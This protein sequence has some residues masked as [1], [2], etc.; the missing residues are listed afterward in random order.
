MRFTL[1]SNT[2]TLILTNPPIGWRKFSSEYTFD[3]KTFGY[4]VKT[5]AG[6]GGLKFVLEAMDY[7]KREVDEFGYRADVTF[8]VE[9]QNDDYSYDITFIGKLDFIGGFTCERDYFE[10]GIYEGGLKKVYSEK[11]GV[12]YEIPLDTD[13]FVPQGIQLIEGVIWNCDKGTL[14]GN[15]GV[16]T[17]GR[18]SLSMKVDNNSKIY[19]NNLIFT[20]QEATDPTAP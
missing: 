20:S 3:E 12:N 14:P 4:S 1:Q 6:S 18:I 7:L 8:I 17:D 13:V 2:E 9:K 16:F 19:T 5:N 11:R 15:F 10:V